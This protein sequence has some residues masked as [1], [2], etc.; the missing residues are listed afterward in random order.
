M[1]SK[2]LTTQQFKA[3]QH[4]AKSDPGFKAQGKLGEFLDSWLVCEVL[5]KKL[6]MY[7]KDANELPI[8]WQYTQLTAALNEF[9][10]SY[11]KNRVKA[12]FKSDHKAKRGCRPAR[13]LRNNFIHTLSGDDRDEIESRSKDLLELLSYWKDIMLHTHNKSL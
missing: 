13:V 3:L 12:A 9:G 7:S 1:N 5:A 11:D 6:I 8:K 4:V 10:Y 2:V